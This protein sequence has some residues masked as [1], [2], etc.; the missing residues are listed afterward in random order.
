[1]SLLLPF[2]G[3]KDAASRRCRPTSSKSSLRVIVASLL[4]EATLYARSMDE[5]QRGKGIA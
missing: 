2:T 5:G 1:M 4:N 3:I